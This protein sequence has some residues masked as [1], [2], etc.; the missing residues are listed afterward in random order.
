M[1]RGGRNRING[2]FFFWFFSFFHLFQDAITI[3]YT[4][5]LKYMKTRG[6][7]FRYKNV[8]MC[9]SHTIFSDTFVQ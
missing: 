7:N 4:Q 9:L 6:Y 1:L 3:K 2:K 8:Q 5:T